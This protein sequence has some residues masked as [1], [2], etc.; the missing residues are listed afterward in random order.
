LL[1]SELF[2]HEKGAFTGAIALK[3]GKLEIANGGTVF[4][5]EV[6]ELSPALQSKLLRVLQEREIDRLGGVRPIAI[7]VRF[8]AATNKDLKNLVEKGSFRN[9]LY[10]RLNVVEISVP[11][12]RDRAQDII[13]LAKYFASKYGRKSQRRV[14]GITPEALNILQSYS[15]PG[16]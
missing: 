13:L 6:A 7:D 12:L 2:G 11:P 5:D 14:L 9:D 16:N 1:E 8:I 4:L 15:W 3:K 10:F